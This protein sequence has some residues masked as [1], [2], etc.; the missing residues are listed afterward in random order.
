MEC[1]VSKGTSGYIVRFPYC[2]NEL[3]HPLIKISR[4]RRAFSN[5]LLSSNY[6]P[7]ISNGAWVRA[8]TMAGLLVPFQ[9][10]LQ[11]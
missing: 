2:L 5:P 6:L 1:M 4:S 3:S 10:Q 9:W 8:M 7:S 11:E